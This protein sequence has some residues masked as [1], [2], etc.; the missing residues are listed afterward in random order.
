MPTTKNLLFVTTALLAVTSYLPAADWTY[1]RGPQFDGHSPE[2]GLPDHWDAKGGDDSHLLWKN[3]ELGGRST[4]T[5]MNDRLYTI[6]RAE[7][8]TSREG[9]KVVCADAATGEILWE[10]RFNVWL[11]DV[12]DTRVGWSSVACDPETGNVYVLGVCD[13]F[14]C[15]NGETGETIWSL[16]LHEQFGMLSTYGGRTNFPII[17]DDLVIISGVIINYAD[18]AKPNHRF[19]GFDKRTGKVVWFS[20]TRDLPDDTTYSAPSL[21]TID[22]QQQ[23]IVGAGD[24]SVWGFQPQTGKPLWHYALSRRGLFATPLVVGNRVFASHSEENVSGTSMGAIV[25]LDIT[26]T[27]EDTKATE[28]WKI[29]QLVV[30]RSTPVE[31]DGRL[32]VVDDRCKLHVINAET[33]EF[34]AE[35]ITLGDSRQWSSLLVADGK[36]YVLTENGRWAI[37]KPT[38]DGAELLNR[39]RIRNEGFNASPIAANGRLYFR[40]K[41]AMYCVGNADAK[42]A[43]ALPVAAKQAAAAK[44][45]AV[46]W[47]QV[48]PAEATVAPGETVQFETRLYDALGQ[49]IPGEQEVTYRVNGGGSFEG[50]TYTAPEGNE[51]VAVDVVAELG[52][53]SGEARMR[54]IPPLPWKFDFDKANDAPVT[55]IGARYRHVI[56]TVDGSPALVKITTIPKGA[57]SRAWMGPSSLSNYTIEADAKGARQAQKLPDIGLV[58]QGYVLDLQGEN[59][60]LQIRTWAAQLR[61]ASTI[62]FPW[63]EDVWYRMKLKVVI[64]EEDGK[65]VAIVTGKIWPKTESEPKEWTITAR[66]EVPNLTGSPGLYGNAKDA[67]LYLDNVQVIAND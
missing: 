38:A 10:N 61:M 11:S 40:G 60:E 43:E 52:D 7:P 36:L 46:A 49:R 4:P 55:W 15:I 25:A 8:G 42:P 64:E 31:L 13:Y 17:A 30:G 22:G 41:S 16:P 37:L 34:I 14:L 35:R 39:D 5:V 47:V 44:D 18:K 3:E 50:A 19:I 62:D 20:G 28:A 21:V 45:A 66:D 1:W 9:E 29:E 54:V 33:G 6:M 63:K 32:Y 2:T 27:G 23:L 53:I 57:R 65:P 26:G 58:N 51:H 12:P 56:R 24:G 59:Q 67:E 48:I